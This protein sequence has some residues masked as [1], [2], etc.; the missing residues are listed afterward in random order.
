MCVAERILRSKR[1]AQHTIQSGNA[2]PIIPFLISTTSLTSNVNEAQ[3]Q[4]KSR[5]ASRIAT[6]TAPAGR[7]V[8]P[9]PIK[10]QER[11]YVHA[12]TA[13]SCRDARGTGREADRGQAHARWVHVQ[14]TSPPPHKYGSATK[15]H[16]MP[17]LPISIPS[18]SYAH[19][20]ACLP[21]RASLCS[22]VI[23]LF[24]LSLARASLCA[25]CARCHG[26]Q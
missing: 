9:S 6:P 17:S 5:D 3:P 7:P 16:S 26:G 21:V 23:S 22:I 15:T 13:R 25:T 2:N 4:R 10:T 20:P 18:A 24:N 19:L 12:R 14:T 8:L 1:G 11:P